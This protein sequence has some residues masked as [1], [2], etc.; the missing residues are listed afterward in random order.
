MKILT[1]IDGATQGWFEDAC[2]FV[3][4]R[5]L[6]KEYA[7]ATKAWRRAAVNAAA[8]CNPERQPALE[9]ELVKAQESLSLAQ[10]AI[11]EYRS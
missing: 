11:V 4:A 8:N 1:M 6:R 10:K 2:G 9:V 5:K 3:G 7:G